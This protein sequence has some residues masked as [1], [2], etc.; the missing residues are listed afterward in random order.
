VWK[1]FRHPDSFSKEFSEKEFFLLASFRRCKFLLDPISVGS[2]LQSAIGGLASDFNVLQLSD[3]VFRFS[4]FC[5]PRNDN[6]GLFLIKLI[7]QKKKEDPLFLTG[8]DH[9]I[10]GRRV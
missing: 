2:L 1:K 10:S 9:Q 4:V 6:R 8:L 5:R 7:S 3:R